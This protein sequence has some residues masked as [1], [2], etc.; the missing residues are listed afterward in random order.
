MAGADPTAGESPCDSDIEL[1]GAA[2]KREEIEDGRI[3]IQT[4]L[5]SRSG[6]GWRVR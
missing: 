1:S 6:S 3:H 4:A 5:L 2:A